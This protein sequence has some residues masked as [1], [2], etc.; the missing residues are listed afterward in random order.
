M[1]LKLSDL[2]EDGIH[3]QRQK[4]K[5]S[6]GKRII[7]EWT[8]ELINLIDEIKCLPPHRIGDAHL[9]I[10][11]QGKPYYNPETMRC[12]ACAVTHLIRCGSDSWIG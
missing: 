11:R 2:K 4:A 5:N 12:N 6:T 8:D 9:F 7:V 10:T 3:S 1:K